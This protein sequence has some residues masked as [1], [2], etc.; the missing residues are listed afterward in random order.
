MESTMTAL[1]ALAGLTFSVSIA[2]VIEE[3]LLGKM[4]QLLFSR[5]RNTQTQKEE[6]Y[7]AD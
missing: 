6:K 1:Y 4:F 2:L 5:N 3:L 7:V